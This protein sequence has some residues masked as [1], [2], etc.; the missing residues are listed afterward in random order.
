M[1]I[2]ILLIVMTLLHG[3]SYSQRVKSLNDSE[4]C[5]NLGKYTLYG[6]IEG[7]ELTQN[8]IGFRYINQED[9]SEIANKTIVQMIPTYK[10]ELCQNLAANHY[11]G[12]YIQFKTTLTKIENLGF[13]DDECNTMADFYLIRLSRKQEKSQALATALN[14]AAANIR[15]ANEQVNGRGSQFNPVHVKFQ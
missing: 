4:L 7:I 10:L 13:A 11:R 1:K 12:D 15:H 14:Q 2:I 9:C 8:E 3:C 5:E 6:H